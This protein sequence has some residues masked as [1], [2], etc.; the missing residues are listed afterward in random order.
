M[1]L[2]TDR[3]HLEPSY[4]TD[5]HQGTYGNSR[6]PVSQKYSDFPSPV[7]WEQTLQIPQSSKNNL[8]KHRN[9]VLAPLT[10]SPMA[11]PESGKIHSVGRKRNPSE[12]RERTSVAHTE[13]V[14]VPLQLAFPEGKV[15]VAVFLVFCSFGWL[16]GKGERFG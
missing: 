6:I 13:R 8:H 10:P 4:P 5:I 15:H 11:P 7:V 1:Q 14:C 12:S 9:A 16:E 3:G 2:C